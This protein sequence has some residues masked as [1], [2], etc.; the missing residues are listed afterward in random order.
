MTKIKS[1]FKK[2]YNMTV[3]APDGSLTQFSQLKPFTLQQLQAQVDGMI[4]RVGFFKKYLGKRCDAYVNEE[5]HIHN[6]PFNHEATQLWRY[7]YPAAQPLVG[8]LVITYRQ[9]IVE[10]S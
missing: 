3:I 1:N 2:S 6:L 7:Q 8:N 4:E 9:E 5:G 10:I